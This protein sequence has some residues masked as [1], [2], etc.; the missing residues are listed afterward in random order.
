MWQAVKNHGRMAVTHGQMH[1]SEKNPPLR[2]KSGALRIFHF[3]LSVLT[4]E[5]PLLCFGVFGWLWEF[6]CV[7]LPV[8]LLPP[9]TVTSSINSKDVVPL[10]APQVQFRRLLPVFLTDEVML[11]T[12]SRCFPSLYFPFTAFIYSLSYFFKTPWS[13]ALFWTVLMR[14]GKF[15][16]GY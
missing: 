5:L 2:L 12:M 14:H 9:S 4:V 13:L 7:H 10:A 16:Q 1:V 6:W 11:Q 3:V 15:Q 8:H